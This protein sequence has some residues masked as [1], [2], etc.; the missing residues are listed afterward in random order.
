[1]PANGR[2]DLGA[3]VVAQVP[4]LQVPGLLAGFGTRVI[5]YLIDYM[6]PL[7]VLYLLLF[8]GVVAGSAA[9][10]VVLGAVGYLGLLGF[11]IWNSGYM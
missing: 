7:I 9:L 8:I 11:T 3:P 6:A 1:M 2:P 5:S 10:S 4:G